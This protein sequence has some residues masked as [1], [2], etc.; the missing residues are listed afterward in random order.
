MRKVLV[1]RQYRDSQDV[2]LKRPVSRKV[3]TRNPIRFNAGKC[4]GTQ[5]YKLIYVLVGNYSFLCHKRS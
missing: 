2:M 4:D 1:G 5:R 3:A